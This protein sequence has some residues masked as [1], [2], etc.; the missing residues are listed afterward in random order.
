MP[1]WKGCAS[2]MQAVLGGFGPTKRVMLLRAMTHQDCKVV[3]E[4]SLR[5]RY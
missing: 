5:L 2:Q 1:A 3:F 4:H